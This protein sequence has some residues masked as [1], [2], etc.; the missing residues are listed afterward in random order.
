MRHTYESVYDGVKAINISGVLNPAIIFDIDGTLLTTSNV[1]HNF[2]V[3]SD[4][5]KWQYKGVFAGIPLMIEL[6]NWCLSQ[7]MK[8]FIITGRREALREATITNLNRVNIKEYT[9]IFFKPNGKID[10]GNYKLSVRKQI[11]NHY[12][13]IANIGDQLNDLGEYS[14]IEYLLPALY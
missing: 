14:G 12:T 6:Y 3:S 1:S 4:V 13:I 9:N 7:G 2:K 11:S 10:T 8:V 5:F